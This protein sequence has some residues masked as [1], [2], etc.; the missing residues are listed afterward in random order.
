MLATHPTRAAER[1]LRAAMVRDVCCRDD[2]WGGAMMVCG[3][4]AALREVWRVVGCVCW[5]L[6]GAAFEGAENALRVGFYN[7]MTTFE[8]GTRC[9]W[10]HVAVS[11]SLKVWRTHGVWVSVMG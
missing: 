2:V 3:G 9:W 4:R 8:A 10:A 6:C 7:G 1:R 11:M 5:W